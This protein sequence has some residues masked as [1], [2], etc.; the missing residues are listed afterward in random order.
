MNRKRVSL[1][2]PGARKSC[3]ESLLCHMFLQD[4]T[5]PKCEHRHIH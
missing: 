3:S 5:E 2:V 1:G 4:G